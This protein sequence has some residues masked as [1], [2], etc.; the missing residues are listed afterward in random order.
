VH[1]NRACAKVPPRL[2]KNDRSGYNG[3]IA[4]AATILRL[5]PAKG[6][7]HTPGTDRVLPPKLGELQHGRAAAKPCSENFS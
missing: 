5:D 3:G 1:F 4:F 7:I 6:K 2:L